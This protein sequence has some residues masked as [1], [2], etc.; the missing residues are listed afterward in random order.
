MKHHLSR[1]GKLA[2]VKS[3]TLTLQALPLRQREPRACELKV[4]YCVKV[5]SHIMAPSD[6]F[7]TII[8]MD[9]SGPTT[10]LWVIVG[11]ALP[12]TSNYDTGVNQ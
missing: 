9:R 10:L 2:K 8:L 7:R 12:D 5:C 4:L 11:V 6:L 3:F 1:Y